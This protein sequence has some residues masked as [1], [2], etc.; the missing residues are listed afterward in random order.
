M[1]LV[2]YEGGFRLWG[3]VMKV[4]ILSGEIFRGVKGD[5]AEISRQ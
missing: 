3:V 4:E 1:G 2:E 5:G